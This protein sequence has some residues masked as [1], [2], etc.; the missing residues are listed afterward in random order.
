M[1]TIRKAADRGHASHGWLDT[2]HTFSFANYYDPL[3][4]GFRSLRVI[5]DDR[6]L[7]GHGFGMHSHQHMEILT[8]VIHGELEH[9]DSLGNGRIIRPGEVQYMSAAQGIRHS[10]KNPSQTEDVHLLQ[11][12]IEPA[13]RESTPLY[14]DR[15]LSTV[16]PGTLQLIASGDGRLNSFAIRQD[17]DL[18]LTKMEPQ[19]AANHTIATGRALWIH[20]ATGSII[21]NDHRLFAGDAA[22]VTDESAVQLT[23]IESA[24]VLLFDLA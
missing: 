16:S 12:W 11:I 10:E 18:W 4:M 17:V 23:G 24:E 13:T 19:T 14:A 9:R 1:I 5:N 3:W 21:V 7:P 2:W 20:V 6:I 22:A 8:Y 15:A